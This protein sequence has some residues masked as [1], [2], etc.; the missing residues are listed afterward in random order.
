MFRS[1]SELSTAVKWGAVNKS[2]YAVT[3]DSAYAF[4]SKLQ[5][6]T[7]VTTT[8]LTVLWHHHQLCLRMGGSIRTAA[9]SQA[10]DPQPGPAPGHSGFAVPGTVGNVRLSPTAGP[11]MFVL[12][13]V[14]TKITGHP[15]PQCQQVQP[16]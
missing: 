6:A 10:T 14:V 5:C 8:V 11:G 3:F 15:V 7:S 4:S 2:L 16:G 12:P 13:R 9:N 1:Q